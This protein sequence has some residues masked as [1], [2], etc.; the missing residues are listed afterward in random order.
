MGE[1]RYHKKV[2]EHNELH[3]F[4]T[5]AHVYE[6]SSISSYT[7]FKL[8]WIIIQGIQEEV[9]HIRK[10]EETIQFTQYIKRSNS[11]LKTSQKNSD[12]SSCDF[13]RKKMPG[14]TKFQG[15][16]RKQITRRTGDIS[17][18]NS[19]RKLETH[20][21]AQSRLGI[22][23]K[24]DVFT[25]VCSNEQEVQGQ[26]SLV[27]Y[28]DNNCKNHMT[29]DRA[30]FSHLYDTKAAVTLLENQRKAVKK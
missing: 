26:H 14:T 23:R 15:G 16:S 6:L 11:K 24:L 27:W 2:L 20:E 18:S 29:G 1:G 10:I 5:N 13:F 19:Q 9:Q 8:V 7:N 25:K 28:L 12:Y 3:L 30:W 17:A 21:E 22:K 4:L